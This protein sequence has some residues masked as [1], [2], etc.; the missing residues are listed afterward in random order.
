MIDWE[1]VWRIFD[2]WMDNLE[3]C[4]RCDSVIKTPTYEEQREKMQKIVDEHVKQ[5]G[6]V[7][8][9]DHTREESA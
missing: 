5:A 4:E 7:Q 1:V 2:Q 8:S 9:M 6:E 3:S